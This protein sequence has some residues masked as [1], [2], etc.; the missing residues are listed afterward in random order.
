MLDYYR[1][2][3]SATHSGAPLYVNLAGRTSDE[4]WPQLDAL[5]S[6]RFPNLIPRALMQ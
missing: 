2:R 6:D 5:V 3:P 1:T 4:I